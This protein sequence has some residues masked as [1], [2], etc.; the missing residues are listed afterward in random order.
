M[1]SFTLRQ[2][3]KGTVLQAAQELHEAAILKS[4]PFLLADDEGSHAVLKKIKARFFAPPWTGRS[5]AS[6]G[7]TAWGGAAAYL[8]PP[9]KHPDH[10][11]EAFFNRV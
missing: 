8:T 7:M 11:K 6:L 9:Q 5:R 4:P 2:P 1:Q 3:T 10:K